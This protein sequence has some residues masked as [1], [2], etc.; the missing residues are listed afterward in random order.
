MCALPKFFLLLAI[1]LGT[2]GCASVRCGF[3]ATGGDPEVVV[4]YMSAGDA[5][6]ATLLRLYSGVGLRD[7]AILEL[8]PLGQRRRCA[9]IAG[10]EVKAVRQAVASEPFGQAMAVASSQSSELGVHQATLSVELGRYLIQRQ[11]G[12]IDAQLLEVLQPLE[13]LFRSR[14]PRL[15]SRYLPFSV[16]LPTSVAAS[17]KSSFK[18]TRQE[19]RG[20]LTQ[21]REAP[22]KTE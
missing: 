4:G 6:T 9:A 7:A 13:A 10:P 8:E 16:G 11:P 19:R 2:T 1:G 17:P 15:T 21:S 5:P 3:L 18:R 20:A 22:S 14:F 12:Q